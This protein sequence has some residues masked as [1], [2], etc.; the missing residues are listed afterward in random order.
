MSARAV[1]KAPPRWYLERVKIPACAAI[2]AVLLFCAFP[3]AAQETPEEDTKPVVSAYTLGDQVLSIGLA[4][5]IPLFYIPSEGSEG[6]N[7]T[8]GAA[9]SI[10]WA[11][12]VTGAIRIGAEVG[13]AFALSR[14]NHNTL[15]MLPIL[16][17][18][19]YVLSLY[20]FEVP[21]S[22]GVGMNVVK[23][24]DQ[25]NI[26]LLI[27]PGVGA[28]WIYDSKWSFGLNL[29]WWWDMQFY[30]KDW[31]DA[32]IGNFLAVTVSALYHYQ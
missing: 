22:L 11:A 13:G 8:L 25:K 6:T 16:A 4:P 21:L 12:Y 28:M 24:G 2:L 26:D 27:K 29:A 19:E 10:A 18:A 3:A 1:E 32:R 20:P 17:R 23:Y 7:L 30:P 15:L 9:G 31:N 5:F 14:P